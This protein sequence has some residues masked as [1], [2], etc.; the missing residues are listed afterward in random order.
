M[1]NAGSSAVSGGIMDTLKKFGDFTKNNKDLTSIGA[2]FIGGMFDDEKKAKT[3]YYEAG[4]EQIRSR[5]ANGSAVPRYNVTSD[6]KKP[7]FGQSAPAYNR[8]SSLF[9]AR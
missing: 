8:P 3:D 7:M 9:Y 1:Q 6:Q 5:I 4:A 2:N